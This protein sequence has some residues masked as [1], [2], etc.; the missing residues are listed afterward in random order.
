MSELLKRRKKLTENEARYY[1]IQLV[2]C[3]RY[4]HV[5]LV[6][7]RDLKLGNLFIDRNMRIKVGDFGLATRLTYAEERRRTV[8]GT[9]NYIA[10]E[11]IQGKTGHSFEVDVWSTGIILYTML[12]GTPPFQAEDVKSTYQRILTNCYSFPDNTA[13]SPDTKSLIRK[14]LQVCIANLASQHLLLQQLIII[15]S[16]ILILLLYYHYLTIPVESP[17]DTSIFAGNC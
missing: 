3:L 11:I 13:V 5:N 8:C 9:P 10:P 16:S 1:L 2:E 6:I 14:I 17:R 4:L 15:A 12:I 7:H